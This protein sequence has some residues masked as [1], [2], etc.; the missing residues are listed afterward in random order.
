MLPL[1]AVNSIIFLSFFLSLSFSLS[2]SLR[3]AALTII[4]LQFLLE[5]T[6]AHVVYLLAGNYCWP[7]GSDVEPYLPHITHQ[8]IKFNDHETHQTFVQYY[9]PCDS[10]TPVFC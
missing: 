2:G 9:M 4:G 1:L 8:L 3:L 5:C 10:R 6:H 7:V